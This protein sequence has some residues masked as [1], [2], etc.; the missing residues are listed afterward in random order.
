MGYTPTGAVPGG[1]PMN[2]AYHLQKLGINP[3]LITRVGI[4]EH[5]KQ[6][7]DLL[8]ADMSTPIYPVGL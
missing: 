3:A 1:A 8:K 4:D 7:L 2:V 5:G 6:L